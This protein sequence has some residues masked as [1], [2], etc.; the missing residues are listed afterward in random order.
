[1]RVKILKFFDADPGWKKF[2]SGIL[3]GKKSDLGSGIT[4][5]YPGVKKASNPGSG[6]ATLG[7]LKKSDSN[8]WFKID[9]VPPPSNQNLQQKSDNRIAKNP[10]LYKSLFL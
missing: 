4:S 7:L 6:D 1:L 8:S 3:D 10:D 5:R 2:G 9:T